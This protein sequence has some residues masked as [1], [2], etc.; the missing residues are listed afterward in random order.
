MLN[1][2]RGAMRGFQSIMVLRQLIKAI[3]SYESMIGKLKPYYY[4]DYIIGINTSG[5]L[6]ILLNRLRMSI[7]KCS[8]AY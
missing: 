3:K 7:D 2:D 4:L 1:L 6:A 8:E 5:L